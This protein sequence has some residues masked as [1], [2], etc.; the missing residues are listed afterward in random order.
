[1]N[2]AARNSTQVLKAAK[3]IVE[4]VGWCQGEYSTFKNGKE[5]AFCVEG[6]MRAVEVGTNFSA[7]HIALARLEKTIH[8]MTGKSSMI[9]FNDDKKTTKQMVLQAFDRA[10]N[11]GTK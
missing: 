4:N 6:A 11:K 10:I 9:A 2:R 3:W 5:N 1:M 8:D 7:R